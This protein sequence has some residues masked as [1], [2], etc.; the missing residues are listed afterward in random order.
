MRE[1][2]WITKAAFLS[3][4]AKQILHGYSVMMAEAAIEAIKKLPEEE[5]EVFWDYCDSMLTS[6]AY[7][8]QYALQN[9]FIPA[10]LGLD[11]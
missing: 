6:G 3:P 9:T 4:E 2:P 1:H 7:G 8:L 5:R 10:A 11:T